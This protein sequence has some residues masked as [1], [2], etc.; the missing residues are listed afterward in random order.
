MERKYIYE[1]SDKISEFRE[2]CIGL[3]TPS[4]I[5]TLDNFLKEFLAF[6]FD[7]I[8]TTISEQKEE[9]LQEDSYYGDD[10]L[11]SALG[12]NPVT[13]LYYFTAFAL[14]KARKAEK[15]IQSE[16]NDTEYSHEFYYDK[17]EKLKDYKKELAAACLRVTT[18]QKVRNL[19]EEKNLVNDLQER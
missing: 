7:D 6:H 10:D 18:L 3:L 13:A 1:V 17:M 12:D 11:Y 4:E 5:K 16:I 2:S 19:M 15:S 8:E 9:A 14:I